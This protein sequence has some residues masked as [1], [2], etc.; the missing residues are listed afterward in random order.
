MKELVAMNVFDRA[1]IKV[2]SILYEHYSEKSDKEL[3]V[4]PF[5]DKGTY[6]STRQIFDELESHL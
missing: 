2:L 4:S 5:D 3:D 1:F 6:K